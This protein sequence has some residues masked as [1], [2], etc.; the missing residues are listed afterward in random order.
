MIGRWFVGLESRTNLVEEAGDHV[1]VLDVEVVVWAV[2]VGR[3][4][5][6]E[7]AAVLVPVAPV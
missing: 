5:G 4:D 1:S 7:V 3:D 2:D 6:G